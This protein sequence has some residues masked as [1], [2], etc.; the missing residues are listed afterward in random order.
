MQGSV[1]SDWTYAVTHLELLYN[2][3]RLG[4]ASGFFWRVADRVFLI[5]NWHVLSGRDRHTQQP[6]HKESGALPNRLT[7]LVY[8]RTSESDANGYFQMDV[9]GAT[10]PLLVDG[11][12][13]LALWLEHPHLHRQV[14]V[15]AIDV[16]AAL[17]GGE[18]IHYRTAND[19]EP[20]ALVDPRAGDD[21]FVIGY[22]LGI[23]GGSPVPAWK[24]AS[25]ATEPFIDPG[26]LP[27]VFVDTATRSGMSG[28]L[29]IARRT[30]LGPYTKRDGSKSD[31]LVAFVERIL[32]VYSGRFGKE[33][34]L[35]QLGVVWKRQLIDEVIAGG[36]RGQT[37][38]QR[39]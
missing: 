26:G 11:N 37:E 16:T 25:V 15:A 32:G 34:E 2:D 27:Q 31:S 6:C 36:C 3:A 28:S 38:M 33:Q 20:D 4:T 19:L 10:L 29:T 23:V 24:R 12:P 17:R 9:L 18:P 22:P 30:V 14:D 8:R 13:P 5:S 21:A 7:M 35:A 1:Q 39:T